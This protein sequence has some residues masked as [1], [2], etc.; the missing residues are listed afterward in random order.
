MHQLWDWSVVHTVAAE[1]RGG[2]VAGLFRD[3]DRTIGL[4][5]ARLHGWRRRRP[6]I[7]LAD[8]EHLG[9]GALPGFGLPGGLPSTLHPAGQPPA[10]L[11]RAAVQ[12]FE[13][14]LRREYGRRIRAVAYRQVYA[15]EL[16]VMQRGITVTR[17]GMPVGV[18]YNR[19]NDYED[20]LRSLS[21]SR[22][23]DQRRLVRRIDVD[24]DTTVTIGT[25]DSVDVATFHQLAADA[26][27]RNHTVR[28]PPLRMWSREVFEA[29]LRLP[30]VRV[31]S[32]T[33]PTGRLIAATAM[34]DHP[35]APLM[36]PWGAPPLGQGRRS[37]LWYDQYARQIRYCVNQGRA[38]ILTGK[39]A[40]S[41]KEPLGFTFEPQWTVLRQLRP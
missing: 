41:S 12:A 20:Y 38:L 31:L 9:V 35:I 1:R 26:A 37:G 24:P 16:P 28:W 15:R 18:L 40:Q 32:Y 25:V 29:V 3:G 14:A 33:D 34:F 22:R 11:L 13:T 21:A 27:R 8:V 36:G 6:V 5:V 23:S 2:V 39:G 30:E 17:Q 7:G 19:F 10:E 4:G